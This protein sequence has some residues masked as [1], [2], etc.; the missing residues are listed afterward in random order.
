[1]QIGGGGVSGGKNN[2]TMFADM[3]DVK[4]ASYILHPCCRRDYV[5][6]VVVNFNPDSKLKAS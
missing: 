4:H 3:Y 1:M 2:S 5:V 6:V